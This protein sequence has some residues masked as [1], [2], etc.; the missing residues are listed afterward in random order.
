MAG[1][2]AGAAGQGVIVVQGK[3]AEWAA[4]ELVSVE[5]WAGPKLKWVATWMQDEYLG[6]SSKDKNNIRIG[7]CVSL[8]EAS[9][10]DD[11]DMTNIE[12]EEIKTHSA[13]TYLKPYCLTDPSALSA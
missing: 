3:Q 13:L 4:H 11:Q 5:Y 12:M 10:R 2:E 9:T 7:Q 1:R 6:Y 8:V